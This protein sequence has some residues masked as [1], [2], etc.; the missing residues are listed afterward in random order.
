MVKRM[1]IEF[2]SFSTDED[3]IENTAN[4]SDDK[5]ERNDKR[6]VNKPGSVSRLPTR[7]KSEFHGRQDSKIPVRIN[8]KRTNDNNTFVTEKHKDIENNEI[9]PEKVT[10]STSL[11]TMTSDMTI[12]GK[13]TRTAIELAKRVRSSGYG[14]TVN[15]KLRPMAL[16]PKSAAPSS[17][18]NQRE[19]SAKS[20]SSSKTAI[21]VQDLLRDDSRPILAGKEDHKW[22]ISPAVDEDTY[23]SNQ[24]G[25]ADNLKDSLED[26][27]PLTPKEISKNTR[28]T[29]RE[30]ARRDLVKIEEILREESTSSDLL[31]QS[32]LQ[33]RLSSIKRK[34]ECRRRGLDSRSSMGSE[35][36]ALMDR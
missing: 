18:V 11:A 12:Q 21:T 31:D 14:V 20:K 30:T 5:D 10:R 29:N 9:F 32:V 35:F 34:V 27:D 25:E 3:S 4:L 15:P 26:E 24:N 1:L 23:R 28:Y 22:E 8:S 7:L 2:V 6:L 33:E 17:P 16:K 13:R 36:D 19:S